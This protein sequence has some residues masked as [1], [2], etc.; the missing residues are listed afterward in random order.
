MATLAEQATLDGRQSQKILGDVIH[1]S[2]TIM[3][4]AQQ[5]LLNETSLNIVWD[6]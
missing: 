1:D 6:S 4:Q 5:P 2:Q 3:L